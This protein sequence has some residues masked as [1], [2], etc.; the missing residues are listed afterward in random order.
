[1]RV[2]SRMLARPIGGTL[3]AL[4]RGDGVRARFHVATLSGRLNG[5]LGRR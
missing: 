5:L 1:V 4:A 3:I 2:R